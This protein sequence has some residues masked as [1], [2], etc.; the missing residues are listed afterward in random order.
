MNPPAMYEKHW[1]YCQII[2]N[3]HFFAKVMLTHS[4]KYSS[5]N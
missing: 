5:V 1:T 4:R 2:P 3:I